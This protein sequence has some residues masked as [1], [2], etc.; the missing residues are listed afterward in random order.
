MKNI[1]VEGLQGAGKSTLVNQ[2]SKLNPNLHVCRE[3]D[4]N[5]LDT[6]WCAVMSRTQYESI[7]K[8]YQELET[9]IRENT[10]VE[11]ET[12]VVTYTKIHTQIQG[13]YKEME[14]HEVYCGRKPWPELK[15]I[16]L[17]RF[18]EFMQTGY[19]F[20]C[21][22]FQNIVEDLILF[23]TLSDEEILRF[24][25]ELF[26]RMQTQDFQLFYLYSEHLE[27]NIE[28]IKKERCDDAGKEIWYEMMLEYFAG[29]PYGKTHGYKDFEDLIKHLKHR[30]Q[31]E[32]SIMR[33]V[34]GDK[35]VVLPSKEYDI[36][37]VMALVG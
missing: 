26:E 23:H 36:S 33:E 9:E 7:L 34:L 21:A 27:K 24:Y 13:F 22:L 31:L 10:S 11:K 12:Y 2:I 25:R 8:M 19:L 3:G 1:Y 18:G 37:Q 28:R 17:K 14:N 6:A 30:Q 35:A 4:Y 16:I 32:L 5:P 29:S 20:E 15:E